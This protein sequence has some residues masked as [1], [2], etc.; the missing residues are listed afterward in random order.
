MDRLEAEDNLKLIREVME[1]SARY[2]HLSG[3]PGVIA[4]LLALA[5]CWGTIELAQK[6]ALRPAPD[7][8]AMYKPEFAAIWIGVFVLAISQDI[9]LGYLKT[10]KTGEPYFTPAFWQV[11][12]AVAP[13][14]FVGAVISLVILS[15][16]TPDAIPPIWTLCYGAAL[17]AAGIFTVKEVRVFGVI[18]LV[19]GA[20]GLVFFSYPET[21]IL[22]M[23]V[24]FGLSHIIFGI[25]MARRYGW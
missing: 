17:C 10:R 23:A 19:I 11:M 5:G 3:L 14:V 13:G 9:L 8:W 21:S 25:W 16:N 18:E 6:A 24:S 12:K 1:R 20:V 22:F 7:N 2:T 4:G 15:Q